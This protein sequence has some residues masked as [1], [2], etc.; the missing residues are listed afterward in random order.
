[1]FSVLFQIYLKKKKNC[2]KQEQPCQLL[3]LG[4][5]LNCIYCLPVQVRKWNHWIFQGKIA[6]QRFKGHKKYSLFRNQNDAFSSCG[7]QMSHSVPQIMYL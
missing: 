4:Y 5:L 1:M 6:K 2:L 7:P 3:I